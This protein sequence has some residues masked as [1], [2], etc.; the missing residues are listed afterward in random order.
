MSDRKTDAQ[1]E[2]TDIPVANAALNYVAQPKMA[3]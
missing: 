1:N 2:E 3:A